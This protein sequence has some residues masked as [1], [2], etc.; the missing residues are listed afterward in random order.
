MSKVDIIKNANLKWE[1]LPEC[2]EDAPYIGNGK[3]GTIFWRDTN[4]NLFFEM[5][6]SDYYDH[7]NSNYSLLHRDNRLKL[8]NFSLSLDNKPISG[9]LELDLYTACVKGILQTENSVVNTCFFACDAA[10]VLVF[11]FEKVKGDC[12]VNITFNPY[13]CETPRQFDKPKDYLAY[14]PASFKVKHGVCVSLQ[15]LPEDEKY[16]NVGKGEGELAVAWCRQEDNNFVRIFVSIDY[17]Y[18]GCTAE[19]TALDNIAFAKEQGIDKLYDVHCKFWHDFYENAASVLL[20]DKKLQNYYYLQLYRFVSGTRQDGVLLD[21]MGPW[22]KNTGWP[23]V[24][25]NLNIQLTYSFMC[26]AN[27]PEYLK[28]LVDILY[29]NRKM[30]SENCELGRSD[31]YV[32]DRATGLNLSEKTSCKNEIGNLAYT[33]YYLWEMYK[34]EMDD[35]FLKN[36]LLDLMTGALKFLITKTYRAADGKLHILPSGSP[37]YTESVEDCTYTL[38]AMRWLA[39]T[40]LYAYERLNI[41]DEFEKECHDVL[42]NLTEYPVDEKTGYM[43]GK[44]M[45]LSESHVHFSH[46]FMIYPYYEYTFDEVDDKTRKLMVKSVEHW[47]KGVASYVGHGLVGAS[48][49]CSLM[50]NGN[51]ALKYIYFCLDDK[52]NFCYNGMY[53]E[54]PGKLPVIESPFGLIRSLQDMLVASY[55]DVIRVLPAIPD[56]WDDIEFENMRTQGAFIVSVKYKNKKITFV[57]IESLM[58]EKCVVKISNLAHLKCNKELIKIDDNIAE[59]KLAK[60][61]TVLFS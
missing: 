15:K 4:K 54:G 8:G 21:L 24:W 36:K 44:D 60:G 59:I 5:G 25:W 29:D 51:E 34:V 57:K 11:E 1:N 47:L 14:P 53:V 12:D 23:G 16:N 61:E 49:I 56:A 50:G 19:K 55:N 18:P 22:Y 13:A 35:D 39:R 42:E 7:R 6:R 17:S 3:I 28:P 52:V 58:G 46:L 41:A 43:I 38:C 40:I 31:V 27:H 30:L 37:E 20:C 48:S 2:W 9:N 45:P 33:L 10:D 26:T 32:I